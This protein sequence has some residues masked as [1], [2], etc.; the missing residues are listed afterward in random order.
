[1]WSI[2]WLS[3]CVAP[4]SPGGGSPTGTTPTPAVDDADGDGAVAAL[5]CDDLDP[6][7]APGLPEV[8]CDGRD[9]D[10]AGDGDLRGD[11]DRTLD[12]A[13]VTIFVPS[14]ALDSQP[15]LAVV[16]DLTGDGLPDLAATGTAIASGLDAT[17]IWSI[18]SGVASP[19]AEIERDVVQRDS[20]AG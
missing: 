20:G 19:A 7:S 6:A 10:C 5:D 3:A 9:N 18:A 13:D 2:L 14:G 16:P 1:M 12:S 17:S 4:P 8:L 15:A 11:C